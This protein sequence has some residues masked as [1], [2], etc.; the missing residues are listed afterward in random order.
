MN[1]IGSDDIVWDPEESISDLGFHGPSFAKGIRVK[2]II[3]L[4]FVILTVALVVLKRGTQ[5]NGYRNVRSGESSK[6]YER[7]TGTRGVEMR[8]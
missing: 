7:R 5:R 4:L 2:W 3:G 8:M 1:P 6:D